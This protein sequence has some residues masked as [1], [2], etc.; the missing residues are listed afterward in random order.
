MNGEIR[1]A[2]SLGLIFFIVAFYFIIL[3]FNV[4]EKKK[5]L[6]EKINLYSSQVDDLTERNKKLKEEIANTGNT[7]YIEKIGRE[8]FD[9][10]KPGENSVVFITREKN[11]NPEAELSEEN[12]W[13]SR[14]SAIWLWFKSKF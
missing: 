1:L 12:T 2:L 6:E 4:F 13:Q 11:Q 14:L 5:N 9:M 7:D 3:D 10:Q 8:E